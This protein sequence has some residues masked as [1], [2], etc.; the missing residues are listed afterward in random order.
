[1]SA[2]CDTSFALAL[3]K[4]ER[5]RQVTTKGY[6]R[7]HDDQHRDGEL[8]AAAACYAK[9]HRSETSVSGSW[10]F[11]A[12]DWKPKPN[13]RVREL[14]VAASLIVAEVERL[15]RLAHRVELD[16]RAASRTTYI[17]KSGPGYLRDE[18]TLEMAS[19]VVEARRF[20][21]LEAES[22]ARHLQVTGLG[23]EVIDDVFNPAL[24]P[25]RDE[26]GVAAHPDLFLPEWF[27]GNPEDEAPFV[28]D[29]LRAAGWEA[30]DVPIDHELIEDAHGNTLEDRAWCDAIAKWQPEPPGGDRWQLVCVYNNEDGTF[31]MFVRRTEPNAA[32][33]ACRVCGCTDERACPGGCS[34]V[35]ADLCSA[36]APG[37]EA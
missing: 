19:D 31:A 24:M 25:V 8:A 9:P 23:C 28:A 37:G 10:P 14:V 4:A 32:K 2:R 33:R 35:E 26:E 30:A 1:M 20:T 27:D 29:Y 34:W 7:E 36:C 6:T 17:V 15:E 22:L 11:A 13:D 21:K 3:I 12:T 16:R 5:I 18:S